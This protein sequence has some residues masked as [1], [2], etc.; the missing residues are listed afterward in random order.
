MVNKIE[1]LR[2]VLQAFGDK[3]DVAGDTS[4]MDEAEKRR[5]RLLKLYSRKIIKIFRRRK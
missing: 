4:F 2:P 5:D 3:W 1:E